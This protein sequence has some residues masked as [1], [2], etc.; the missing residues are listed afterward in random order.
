MIQAWFQDP[1]FP[2][3]QGCEDGTGSE[4]AEI[5]PEVWG[6]FAAEAHNYMV[7]RFLNSTSQVSS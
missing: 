5:Q 2:K 1:L 4:Q 3:R 6:C 7:V